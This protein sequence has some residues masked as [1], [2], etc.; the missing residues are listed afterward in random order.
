MQAGQSQGN[1]LR[2]IHSALGYGENSAAMKIETLNLPS[3]LVPAQHASI[4]CFLSLFL[5]DLCSAIIS[6]YYN[7]LLAAGQENRC[8]MPLVS[9]QTRAGYS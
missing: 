3:V 4:L 8:H 1:F 2:D 7:N 6:T 5:L 9:N